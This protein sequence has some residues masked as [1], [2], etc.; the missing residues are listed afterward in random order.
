MSKSIFKDIRFWI[1]L[2]FLIRLF[3]ITNPPLEIA[4]N[5]RQVTG[6]MVARNFYEVDPNILYPRVDMAGERTGITGT[7]FPLFNYLIFLAALLFGWADWYGRL[8][9]L[10]ITSIGI[11]FFYRI[12]A[13]FIRRDLAFYAAFILLNS[14]WFIY[15]RKTMPDTFSLA[16]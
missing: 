10:I 16:L 12:I 1:L 8:I 4:H 7:E 14:L 5:W 6:L 9:N 2:Y 15:A 13:D 3:G 11:Y